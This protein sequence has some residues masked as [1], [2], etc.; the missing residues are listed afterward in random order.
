MTR[1]VRDAVLAHEI[2]SGRKVPKAHKPL[3]AYRLA[4]AQN[5]MQDSMDSGVARAFE[6][7]LKNL[8]AAG[9]QIEEIALTELLDIGPM[10][11]TGGFSPAESFAWHREL[12]TQHADQY[13]PRVAHR[14]QR[15]AQMKAHEY[16]QLQSARAD[17]IRLMESKLQRY[18]AVLSPTT[19]ISAPRLSELAPGAERDDAFFRVNALLLR[20]PS[21]VN[22]LDGCAIS[23]PCH[24]P[25]ELPVGMMAWHAAMHDDALLQLALVMEPVL[26]KH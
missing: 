22:T 6:R 15:G 9:A 18:D 20:N 5:V 4:V 13:D 8:R 25:G 7:S 24:V 3:S 17:W 16:I 1:S 12:L 21:A 14:I 10:M 11:A 23:M 19:P 26:Q 2:L